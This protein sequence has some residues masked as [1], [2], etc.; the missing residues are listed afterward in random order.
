[1]IRLLFLFISF[2]ITSVLSAQYA[3]ELVEVLYKENRLV[4]IGILPTVAYLDQM[5]GGVAINTT[6]ELYTFTGISGLDGSS[7]LYS[8]NINTGA[9]EYEVS[10]PPLQLLQYRSNNNTFIGLHSAL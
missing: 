2:M 3:E 5:Q 10:T 7:N 4:S 1:M 6:D 8:V 9:V